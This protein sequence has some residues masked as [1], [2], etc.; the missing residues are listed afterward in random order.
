[1]KKRIFYSTLAIF[2]FFTYGTLVQ[3]ES[4]ELILRV[5]G[6]ACPFCAYGLEKKVMK[7]E[8]TQSYD[9]DM[10][11]GEVYIG[12]KDNA[13]IDIKALKK[14][15]KEAGFTLRSISHKSNGNIEQ[16][17]ISKEK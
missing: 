4:N 16:L 11:K 15:V 2:L 3:A 14:A 6:L 5:D 10:K 7:L 1:M 8:A 17:D 12:F 9:V 13:D